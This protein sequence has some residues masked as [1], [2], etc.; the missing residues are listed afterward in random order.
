MQ[1]MFTRGSWFV[2]V[3]V[4]ALV[5]GLVLTIAGPVSAQG[6]QG[7]W[8]QAHG[9]SESTRQADV[10]GPATPGIK[11]WADLREETR[12]APEGYTIAGASQRPTIAPDGKVLLRATNNA[13][14]DGQAGNRLIALDPDDGSVAW[15]TPDVRLSAQ[16]VVDS[17]GRI[18]VIRTDE[19]DFAL[20]ALDASDG[21][22][23]PG[24]RI[25]DVLGRDN[26]VIG[27]DPE[28]LLMFR[29][30]RVTG[31]VEVFDISGSAPAR[32]WFLDL[33]T[34]S[35]GDD[36]FAG[37]VDDASNVQPAFHGSSVVLALETEDG[38]NQMVALDLT[39]AEPE[40][41]GEV[42]LPVLEEGVFDGGGDAEPDYHG[43]VHL[44][45]HADDAAFLGVRAGAGTD[46]DG[47]V[48]GLDLAGM[49]IEWQE[50]TQ[51][52]DE[53]LSQGPGELALVGD[54]VVTQT[55]A[56]RDIRAFSVE[57]GSLMWTSV[58]ARGTGGGQ[59][60]SVA[61]DVGGSAYT[62]IDPSVSSSPDISMAAVDSQ[63][64]LRWEVTW[65]SVQAVAG[66]ELAGGRGETQRH[67]GPIDG[68]GTLYMRPENR[69]KL[70]AFDNSGD[71]PLAD[72]ED[73]DRTAGSNRIETSV[74]LSQEFESADSVVIARS[75]EYPDALAGA[76][77]ATSLEAPILLTPSGSLDPAVEAEIERLG[78]S[79]AILLGGTAALSSSVESSLLGVVDDT[80]RYAGSN[81]FDTAAQIA[82]DVPNPSSQAFVVQGQDPE[83]H[84][85][86]PDA[87][88]VSALAAFT[89]TPILLTQTD[90]LPSD[91][92]AALGDMDGAEIVGGTAVVSA[93]VQ[94]S[95]E[96]IVGAAS[97]DRTAGANRWD[98]SA[99]LADA[100]VAHGMEATTTWLATGSNWPD[101]LSAAPVVG[102]TAPTVAAGGG[103]LL[104]VDGDDLDASA[105]TRNWISANSG[106][107]DRIRV[108]GGTAV[109]SDTVRDQARDHADID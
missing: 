3:A 97:V 81:R 38:V 2:P 49:S 43:R 21:S 91:T 62:Q 34:A 65:E 102:S 92:A 87:V 79:E 103:V 80:D 58:S 29:D 35:G 98:T 93:A 22:P 50:P 45:Q 108:V 90:T 53:R 85:G 40:V 30:G 54:A 72:G 36:R 101:S 61:T 24:T 33:E 11:W 10:A 109:I 83:P 37:L 78:A 51:D 9:P 32:G 19:D 88:A 96:G 100:A 17:Q 48:A 67:V 104:L 99:K 107:I 75:D 5:L 60:F 27:G 64:D 77:L 47:Y 42:D 56:V 26:L 20:E 44:V 105:E 68:D 8:P 28:H 18:W 14:A 12:A 76:P 89:E 66:E 52:A 15:D 41:V 59:T 6:D 69:D 13:P 95:V 39:A 46:G 23:V 25:D 70:I 106:A 1:Q 74:E 94:N 84:R 4:M 82:A 31:G 73:P 55:H 63:G 86:W 16:Q 7:H 71:L 57:D